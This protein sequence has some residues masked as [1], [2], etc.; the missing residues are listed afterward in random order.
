MEKDPQ[1]IKKSDRK[2]VGKLDYAGIKFPVTL[3]DIR[4]IE[5]KNKIGVRVFGYGKEVYTV[6]RSEGKLDDWMNLL[7]LKNE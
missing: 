4:R 7:W 5:K 6:Y 2:M 1:R 3:R